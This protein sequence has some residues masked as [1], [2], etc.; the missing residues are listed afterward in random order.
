MLPP[1]EEERWRALCSAGL[2][3]IAVLTGAGIS[4]ESGVPTF[5]GANGLWRQ[6]NPMQLATPEGF[7]ENPRLVWE[8]YDWRRQRIAAAQ[9]NAGH[10][11]LAE[12][13]QEVPHFT[14]ITQN[15]DG[16]HQQAGSKRVLEL[17]GSLWR[18][19]CVACSHEEEN[20]TVP[21]PSL[22]PYCPRCGHLLRPDV[23]WF[24][25]ALPEEVFAEAV[26]E[27]EQADLFLVV[28]TSA[29]V[30]PAASLPL[31]AKRAGATV[32]EVNPERTPITLE[33]DLSLR[34]TAAV[35]L[36]RLL[37]LFREEQRTS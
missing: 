4:A 10:R 25:E 35:G 9:P 31:W 29:T 36:P 22:P 3:R 17:H 33:A 7:F 34:S 8:W 16:L 14:L 27:A 5:R 30:Q 21:L 32:V 26:Q 20:R 13:E 12:W 11:A 6:F 28:G 24:G 2:R 15:V 1:H 19:R 37:A 23:V 18:L